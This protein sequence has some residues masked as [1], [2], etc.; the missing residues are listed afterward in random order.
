[1]GGGTTGKGIRPG[2]DTGVMTAGI[3]E[4]ENT[5]GI[6]SGVIA[7]IGPLVHS[8]GE[9]MEKGDYPRAHE[10]ATTI[11]T[12]IDKVHPGIRESAGISGTAQPALEELASGLEELRAGATDTLMWIDDYN[13][14]RRKVKPIAGKVCSATD[15]INKSVALTRENAGP[16]SR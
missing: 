1:M 9:A 12:Y 6:I 13:S 2:S 14:L 8:F 10:M 4:E 5:L 11:C 15:H 16:A 7:G 3:R